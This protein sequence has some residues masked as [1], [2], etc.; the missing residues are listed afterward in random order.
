MGNTYLS[1]NHFGV[2]F[3][4]RSTGALGTDLYI[5]NF[6]MYDITDDIVKGIGLESKGSFNTDNISEVGITDRV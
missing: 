5:R 6:Q 3:D 2:G 1:Y 4:Y